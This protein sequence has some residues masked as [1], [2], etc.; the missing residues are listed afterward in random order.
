M[1]IPRLHTKGRQTRTTNKDFYLPTIRDNTPGL[2][3]G[4]SRSVTGPTTYTSLLGPQR[5]QWFAT[6]IG[7]ANSIISYE[8]GIVMTSSSRLP[9]MATCPAEIASSI[10]EL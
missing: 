7:D 9:S 3:K 6:S 8:A 10:E 5:P 1:F 4:H 2:L